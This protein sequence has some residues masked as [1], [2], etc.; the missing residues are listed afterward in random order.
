MHETKEGR[1][2][3][4]F[5]VFTSLGCGWEGRWAGYSSF[6]LKEN[7]QLIIFCPSLGVLWDE[8]YE[9]EEVFD[10]TARS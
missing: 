1:V 9:I 7:V 3:L 4:S 10:C 2:L 8:E 5:S 6:E